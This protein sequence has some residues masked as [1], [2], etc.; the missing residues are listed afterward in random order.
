MRDI[1]AVCSLSMFSRPDHQQLFESLHVCVRERRQ[2]FISE[3]L[4]IK[5]F[6]LSSKRDVELSREGITEELKTR[7]KCE[8]GWVTGFCGLSGQTGSE[9]EKVV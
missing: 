7:G 5:G 8:I 6:I 2:K 9:S 1:Y 4:K 3:Y